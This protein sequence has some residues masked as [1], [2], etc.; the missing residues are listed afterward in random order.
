MHG[1]TACIRC[2]CA[3]GQNQL[4]S[5]QDYAD[6]VQVSQ[7][8]AAAESWQD[9]HS[10]ANLNPAAESPLPAN[11][12]A[13]DAGSECQHAKLRS[14]PSYTEEAFSPPTRLQLSPTSGVKGMTLLQQATLP[15]PKHFS[16]ARP[17]QTPVPSRS[18]KKEHPI[19]GSTSASRP[20]SSHR[21]VKQK[22][23]AGFAIRQPSAM[24]PALASSSRQPVSQAAALRQLL[25]AAPQSSTASQQST[26][27][28]AHPVHNL[29]YC[30]TARH[31]Q[32]SNAPAV[33][34][35]APFSEA[36]DAELIDLESEDQGEAWALQNCASPEQPA[37]RRQ[38]LLD[39][40]I[41]GQLPPSGPYAESYVTDKPP[42]S[43]PMPD[44]SRDTR[45]PTS[46]QPAHTPGM[47]LQRQ[48]IAQLQDAPVAVPSHSRRPAASAATLSARLAAILQHEK[49]QKAHFEATGITNEATM[50]VTIV[51]QQ[52]EGH[53]V[54]CRCQAVHDGPD[55]L[56]VM[57]NT[58]LNKEVKL[59]VG[60]T[61]KL[62]APWT[63]VQLSDCSIP[64]LL[65]YN[66]SACY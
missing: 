29:S 13:A 34:G 3:Q 60:S 32:P 38:S 39:T 65:C 15:R 63:T 53:I 7:A 49:A 40:M 58:K 27:Q 19:Y 31:G 1:C 4:Q 5:Q 66:V 12:A 52:L 56:F 22:A 30:T 21:K 23:N 24:D 25:G 33:L 42:A 44:A 51:Q 37:A 41:D 6:F 9:H 45:L 54:K 47:M 59:Y 10:L 43:T 48:F 18:T 61:V 8:I 20:G 57:F 46:T 55:S 26:A 50:T 36:A 28:A 35:A 17:R 62:H 64:V 11:H 2:C 16:P 14:G